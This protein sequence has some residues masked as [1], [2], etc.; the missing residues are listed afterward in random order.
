[1]LCCAVVSATSSGH[2]NMYQKER[3]AYFSAPR[4]SSQV[5]GCMAV[6]LG[7]PSLHT[8]ISYYLIL[9]FVAL[10]LSFLSSIPSHI[11]N[12]LYI[13]AS[14]LAPVLLHQYSSLVFLT[15]L[16]IQSLSSMLLLLQFPDRCW[17]G[18][19]RIPNVPKAPLSVK[20]SHFSHL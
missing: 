19:S 2:T 20:F 9:L 12:S 18:K 3:L 10:V 6:V 16:P 14:L 13:T 1:M 11:N 8:L 15:Y 17:P 5:Q 4:W 7:Q